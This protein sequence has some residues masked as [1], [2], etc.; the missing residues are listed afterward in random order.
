MRTILDFCHY[1]YLCEYT[2]ETIYMQQNSFVNWAQVISS[3]LYF[4]SMDSHQILAS[5]VRLNDA[6]LIFSLSDNPML[7]IMLLVV[8]NHPC[9]T[10]GSIEPSKSASLA[11]FQVISSGSYCAT[12]RSLSGWAST[13]ALLA[14][15]VFPTISWAMTR[16]YSSTCLYR[17][18]IIS[19]TSAF[20]ATGLVLGWT[21][22][23]GT[24]P[25]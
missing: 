25:D 21:G 22:G 3:M 18:A 8:L 7:L 16:C 14:G 9:A 24:A 4:S 11:F 12:G 23:G 17:C 2:C 13:L 15:Q 6:H 5:I 10:S 19:V 20:A 1:F